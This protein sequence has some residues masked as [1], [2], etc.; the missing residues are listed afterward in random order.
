M[1]SWFW[2]SWGPW[3]Q[4]PG[5][6]WLH[7]FLWG[8]CMLL[9]SV[10]AGTMSWGRTAWIQLCPW[11]LWAALLFLIRGV[12]WD[13]VSNYIPEMSQLWMQLKKLKELS[14]HF[15]FGG[16]QITLFILS[17]SPPLTIQ[18]KYFYLTYIWMNG[19]SVFLN[20]VFQVIEL[21]SGSR[22][23]TWLKCPWSLFAAWWI[24][25][26]VCAICKV[27]TAGG[28]GCQSGVREAMAWA[29]GFQGK[30]RPWPLRGGERKTSQHSAYHGTKSHVKQSILL[31]CDMRVLK[32][33]HT[34]QSHAV[35]T[36]GLV[37]HDTRTCHQ[38]HF[39][40]K[41]ERNLVKLLAQF[42]TR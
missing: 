28:G 11:G 18:C 4:V 2:P 24:S 25:R 9:T 26:E 10:L 41:R 13:S 27:Q 6:L 19:D 39:K 15:F 29:A 34:M 30:S 35:K 40:K 1:S 14:V 20:I 5:G 7:L 17:H 37:R 16:G 12:G 32:S 36:N 42:Y 21:A 22:I 8:S 3:L 33:H 38:C 31:Q 23:C